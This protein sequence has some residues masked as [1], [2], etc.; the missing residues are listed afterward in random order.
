MFIFSLKVNSSK[1]LSILNPKVAFYN[2]LQN[3]TAWQDDRSFG[4]EVPHPL[5]VRWTIC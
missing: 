3:R 4:L 5:Q 2:E 1:T